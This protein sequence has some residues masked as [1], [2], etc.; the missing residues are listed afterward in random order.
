[1]APQEIPGSEFEVEA[2]LVVLAMGFVGPGNNELIESFG[3][4]MDERSNIRAN[5]KLM[6]NAEG[7]F[8]AGD[9][10]IGQS[11]IVRAIDSGRKAAF[12]ISDYLSRKRSKG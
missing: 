1:M 3:V 10:T 12:A 11:L 9:M 5:Q 4:Q 2:E 8:V 6:T 7:V